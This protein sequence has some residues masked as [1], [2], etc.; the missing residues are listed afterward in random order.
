MSELVQIF[1]KNSG[2][3]FNN[4]LNTN[5]GAKNVL[6]RTLR[7]N[8]YRFAE[9][10]ILIQGEAERMNVIL[11]WRAWRDLQDSEWNIEY[12]AGAFRMDRNAEPIVKD[13]FLPLEKDL[14][15]RLRKSE[16][17]LETQEPPYE[18]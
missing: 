5:K 3:M 10:R 8:S 1:S 4:H 14:K 11:Q 2:N 15:Q 17:R 13:G 12:P 6:R 7:I 16:E 9:D 18:I